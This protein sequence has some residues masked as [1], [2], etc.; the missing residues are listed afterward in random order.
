V[1]LQIAARFGAPQLK[2][3]RVSNASEVEALQRLSVALSQSHLA[4]QRQDTASEKPISL[5]MVPLPTVLFTFSNIQHLRGQPL[6]S[7]VFIST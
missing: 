1:V 3:G 4:P 6:T 5:L 2:N 7:K